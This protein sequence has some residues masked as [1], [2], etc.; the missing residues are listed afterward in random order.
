MSDFFKALHEH[1]IREEQRLE[2]IGAELTSVREILASQ[3]A[4]LAEHI[5]R[6][7]R[8]ENLL[9]ATREQA[10]ALRSEHDLAMKSIADGQALLANLTETLRPV[11]ESQRVWVAAG[12][13]LTVA[14]GLA[15]STAGVLKFLGVW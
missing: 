6:S 15:G 2:R 4:I 12:K 3:Q 13:A 11:L 8:L 5:R 1:T 10:A 7:E 9:D 14:A